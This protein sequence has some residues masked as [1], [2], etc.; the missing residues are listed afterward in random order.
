VRD[1]LDLGPRAGAGESNA[2]AINGSGLVVGWSSW[3][4]AG[5]RA[6]TWREGALTG[7]GTLGGKASIALGVN[8]AGVVVGWSESS[9]HGPARAFAC[10]RGGM[11]ELVPFPLSAN[12]TSVAAGINA[13]G[14][15]VGWTQEEQG[16]ARAFLLARQDA[17]RLDGLGAAHSRA[18]SINREGA[19]VGEVSL[20]CG[21]VHGFLHHQGEVVD[22]GTLG[23]RRSAARCVNDQLRAVGSSETGHG[24]EHAFLYEDGVLV[25]LGTLGGA[26]S[27]AYGINNTGWIVGSSNVAGSDPPRHAF[28]WVRGKMVDLNELVDPGYSWLLHEAWAI[29]DRGDIVGWGT[30]GNRCRAF[31]LP[32]EVTRGR[33]RAGTSPTRCAP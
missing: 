3:R 14:D 22:L 17:Q 6:T 27:Y 16:P 13:R 12:A 8:D 1:L 19:I 26:H 24:Q 21:R 23:G 25:D 2:Y 11:R 33:A 15:I 29:N 10:D 5:C 4:N 7:L 9:A 28:V 18:H 32:G 20:A 30:R 31:L